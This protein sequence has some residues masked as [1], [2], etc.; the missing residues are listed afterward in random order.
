MDQ[1]ERIKLAFQEMN[2]VLGGGI[3][4]GSLVLMAGEPGIGKST[5][6][7]QTTGSL[8]NQGKRVLYVTGEESPHQIRLRSER[9]G[10]S[11]QGIYLLAETDV[12]M[13]VDQLEQLK[14][15]LAVIDSIQTLYTQELP[16]GPGTVAQVR[17]CALRIMRWAKARAVPVI[18]AGHTTKE[19]DLAGPRVLEHM[20]DVVL[21]LEGQQLNPYR[22]LRGAKNRFGSTD[23]VGMFQMG[24]SGLEEVPDPSKVLLSQHTEDAIGS[25]IVPVLEGSRPILMEVQA[26]TSPSVL[27]APR[28]VSNGVDYNRLLILTAVL[29]RRAGLDLSG[30]DVIV[31]VAGG[32]RINEPATDLAVALAIA[33]SLKN[34][35]VYSGMIA[36]GEVGLSGE[37]RNVPQLPRRLNEAIRLGFVRCLLPETSREDSKGV[38]GIEPVFAATLGQALRLALP[39]QRAEYIESPIAELA[40]EQV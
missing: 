22:I 9:L 19:G 28:R 30:Q 10:F 11:G 20:V 38:K 37:L 4:P 31:N 13:V 32:L 7:L 39:R 18:L 17:E 5:L 6:L 16:S 26:L 23:E 35:P 12:D 14:P 21:Y 15:G 1:Q 8:A 33:S 25:T 40:E 3:V 24:G 2:R 27:P 29:S 34:S 36:L